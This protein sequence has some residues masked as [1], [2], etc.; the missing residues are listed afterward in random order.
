MHAVAELQD[1]AVAPGLDGPGVGHGRVRT[2]QDGNAALAMPIPARLRPHEMAIASNAERRGERLRLTMHFLR[3]TRSA[4]RHACR[5]D[6]EARRV[7]AHC[8]QSRLSLDD[9][10]PRQHG[11][12]QPGPHFDLALMAMTGRGGRAAGNSSSLLSPGRCRRTVEIADR[13]VASPRRGQPRGRRA[14]VRVGSSDLSS[15]PRN[16]AGSRDRS[17]RTR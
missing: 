9:P 17:R 5:G 11:C 3:S 13:R 14:L 16:A 15:R 1:T 12:A 2:V 4:R 8:F 7:P 10:S 6:Y